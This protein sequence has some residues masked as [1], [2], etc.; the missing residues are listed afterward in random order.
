MKKN[1]T[2]ALL[3]IVAAVLLYLLLHQ[4]KQYDSHN[5]GHEQAVTTNDTIKAHDLISAQIIDGLKK[6]N[7]QLDSANKSLLKGQQ[8][9]QRKLD[10]KVGEVQTLVAQIREINQDTGYFGHLLDSLQQQVES[11]SFLVVQYEQYSD[12]L[13]N[14]N[15]SQK[16]NYEAI[17]KEKDRAKAELQAAYDQLYKLYDN[18]FK[19]YSSARKSLKREKLKT[20]VAA[21]LAL[22]AGGAA[23]LK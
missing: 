7:K 8:Q 3:A 12:S 15:I 1:I 2:I 14:V 21:L 9:T 23:I 18:L 22:V 4:G 5:E 19:D 11:L 10:A 13:T 6:D 20:K 16:E 17:I